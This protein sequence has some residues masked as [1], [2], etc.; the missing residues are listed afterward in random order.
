MPNGLQTKRNFDNVNPLNG[1]PSA[2]TEGFT[3]KKSDSATPKSDNGRSDSAII[4]ES[5]NL[6]KQNGALMSKIPYLFETPI[7]KYFKEMGWFKNENTWKFVSWAFAKCSNQSYTTVY[8]NCE[9]TLQPY[10]F[11]CGRNKSSA[12]CFLT[13]KQFRGQLIM[14]CNEGILKKGANSKANRFTSYIWVVD[15]FSNNKGQLNGQQRANLGPTEGH[16]LEEKNRRYKEDHRSFPSFQKKGGDGKIDDLFSKEE[17]KN[18]IHVFSGKYYNG[19]PCEVYLTQEELDR[20]IQSK[21]SIE[22]VKDAINQLAM[23]PNR[24]YNIKE[25]EKTIITWNFK[26]VIG[27]RIADNEKLGIQIHELYSECKG[28]SARVYRDTI[29]DQRGILFEG[30]GAY[31]TPV[32]ISFSEANFKEKCMEVIKAKQMKKKG[33]K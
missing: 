7:P 20:C 15:R 24:K 19:D 5:P 26:N 17:N 2:E 16:N 12:E 11:I 32:F 29:K 18:K 25:W 23:W 1:K 31:M 30:Q 4:P 13:S 21:G 3:L 14:L 6:Y 22:R 10:E 27:D 8:D 28:W 33:E 9:I